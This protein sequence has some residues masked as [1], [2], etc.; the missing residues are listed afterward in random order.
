[1]LLGGCSEDADGVLVCG[2]PTTNMTILLPFMVML[3]LY[4]VPFDS[5]IQ[6]ALA[7][8]IF[9]LFQV[10]GSKGQGFVGSESRK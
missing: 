4:A 1:M 10:S 3:G 9:A 5:S 2:Q 7:I 8:I 6:P